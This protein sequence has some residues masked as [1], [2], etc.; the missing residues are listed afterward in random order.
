MIAITIP[1]DIRDLKIDGQLKTLPK[2]IGVTNSYRL[3]L[4][5]LMVGWGFLLLAFSV[6][7]SSL[8]VN[9]TKWLAYAGFI[10]MVTYGIISV[11][12]T[13]LTLPTTPYV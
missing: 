13:H 11:S 12:Y 3:S 9:E 8:L 1:F 7:T 4:F 5:L 10:N 6:D 2:M